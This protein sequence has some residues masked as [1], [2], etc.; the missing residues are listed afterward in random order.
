MSK[1]FKISA[2][3]LGEL[4][5]P[6]FCPRCFWIK[7]NTKL[8]YQIFPAI[9]SS[10]DIY[11]KN[12]IHNYFDTYG[13]CP[14]WLNEIGNVIGYKKAPHSS[15]FYI[16]DKDTDII[17]NG[18]PD[19]IFELA[20][21]TFAIIDYKTA[22]FTGAQ[23]SLFPIYNIQLNGYSLIGANNG[24]KPIS[25]LALVYMEPVALKDI[26]HENKHHREDGFF[27]TFAA[28]I[29]NVAQNADLIKPLLYKAKEIF[30]MST[31][32]NSTSGCENC[33]RLEDIVNHVTS[34]KLEGDSTI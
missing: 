28:K 31:A 33:R 29:L 24:F 8:P 25:K 19:D 15:R 9:F 34:K 32:P 10:I 7:S 5:M 2:K 20:D 26:E 1:L 23:D 22:K 21:G 27:M 18:I 16:I 17:L 14:K 13:C 11:T 3:A 4:A 6:N 30:E 12:I